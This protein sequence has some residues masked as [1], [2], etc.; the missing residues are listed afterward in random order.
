MSGRVRESAA[1]ASYWD[2]KTNYVAEDVDTALLALARI[3]YTRA[4]REKSFFPSPAIIFWTPSRKGRVVAG[5]HR[6]DVTRQ[7]SARQE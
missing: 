3:E 7:D 6:Q 2:S 4:C 5:H 1:S